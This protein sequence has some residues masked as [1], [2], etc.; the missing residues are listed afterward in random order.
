MLPGQA[1]EV[2]PWHVCHPAALT[3]APVRIE[4]GKL[5]PRVVRAVAGG[6][7][8][9]VNL[10]VA[11]IL[12]TGHPSRGIHRPRLQLDPIPLPQLART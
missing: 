12:E 4:H 2:Q 1:E 10:E 5:D 11:P 6:P 9:R 8:Q 3:H 7:D